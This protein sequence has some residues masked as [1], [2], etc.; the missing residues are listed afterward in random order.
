MWRI[1][2]RMLSLFGGATGEVVMER[3]NRVDSRILDFAVIEL[4]H[5]SFGHVRRQ[6][7]RFE[8]AVL[9]GAKEI[10]RV[11]KECGFG[12]HTKILFP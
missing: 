8:F 6:S 4:S 3:L 7:D 12:V 2:S 1:S 11:R 9:I 10:E 5:S